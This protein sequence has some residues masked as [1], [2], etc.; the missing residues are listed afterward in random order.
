[1]GICWD[2]IIIH[3][4]L[5]PNI[6]SFPSLLQALVP[7][8]LLNSIPLCWSPS[9]SLLFRKPNVQQWQWSKNTDARVGFWTR[10]P[11]AGREDTDDQKAEGRCYVVGQRRLRW[12]PGHP[13]GYFLAHLDDKWTNT[14]VKLKK[15]KKIRSS[16]AS[17]MRTGLCQREAICSVKMVA[18][19]EQ[20]RTGSRGWVSV[21][22]PA[23]W[24]PT[25]YS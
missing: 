20:S 23:V 9:P 13:P 5:L 1:M 8:I 14:V 21:V 2:C 11:E 3:F 7:G 4:L 25:A 16:E 22:S 6:A 15:G 10:H 12:Q 19:N 18:E 24:A 17:A